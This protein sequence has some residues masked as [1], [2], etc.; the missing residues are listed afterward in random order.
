MWFKMC[1]DRY[2]VGVYTPH[3]PPP[4]PWSCNTDYPKF[5]SIEKIFLKIKI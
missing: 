1:I 4:Y 3:C 5:L 2:I